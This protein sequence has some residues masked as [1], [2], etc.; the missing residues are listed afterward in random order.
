MHRFSPENGKGIPVLLIHGSIE[1]SRIFYSKSGKGLAP[2][3][4]QS[5]FDV[6]VPDLP[7]K[8]KSKPLV[9]KGFHHS[10]QDFIDS[11]F[12]DYVDH[13]RSFH[14][15]EKIRVGAHSWGG[16]LIL[17]WYAKYGSLENFGPMVFFGAKRRVA[18]VSLKRFFMIDLMW[19]LVGQISTALLGYLPA[20]RLK[21]GSDNEPASF[22]RQT[23]RWVYSKDWRDLKTGEDLARKL[24]EKNLPPILYFAG[25]KDT[26]LGNPKDVRR[27]MNE[28]GGDNAS[29]LLLSKEN[30]NAVN[31]GHI[32]M[33]TSSACRED[34][35]PI[36]ESWLKHGN[37]NF[38]V[39]F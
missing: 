15:E 36:A 21:M 39:N 26:V 31:Y 7:G 19:M 27:L 3:L 29:F 35:F 37:S 24:R 33:L 14:P 6:F 4:A 28:T 10:Q 9:K 18:T 16:V 17:A 34:H 20:K 22:Y 13:I 1:D 12:N 8:G 32:N 30:G 2:Y 38:R 25:I 5:G 11:D 23:N